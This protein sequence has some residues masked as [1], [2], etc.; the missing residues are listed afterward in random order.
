MNSSLSI[1]VADAQIQDR[2]RD[3]GRAAHRGAGA[4]RQTEG[5]ARGRLVIRALVALGVRP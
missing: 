1:L 5:S 4:K 2:V 3:S